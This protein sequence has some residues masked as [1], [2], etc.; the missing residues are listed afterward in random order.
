MINYHLLMRAR[1][2]H[3]IMKRLGKCNENSFVN[4]NCNVAGFSLPNL[5]LEL[6][7]YIS[8]QPI[9]T[10][11]HSCIIV[12]IIYRRV[13]DLADD[14]ICVHACSCA[15]A[16]IDVQVDEYCFTVLSVKCLCAC[17]EIQDFDGLKSEVTVDS[18]KKP[19]ICDESCK[20]AVP[21]L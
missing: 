15:R 8:L 6:Q 17:H 1:L 7:N 10:V 3:N 2:A 9:I 11:V 18:S 4:V 14:M 12:P 5:S 21:S 13:T 20:P 19:F 16:P